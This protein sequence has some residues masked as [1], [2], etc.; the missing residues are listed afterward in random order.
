M[1]L[2]HFE[3]LKEHRPNLVEE[4]FEHRTL[5]QYI[6]LIVRKAA[7]HAEE[8]RAG[9]MSPFM[10]A[11]QV[12]EKWIKPEHAK[13]VPSDQRTISPGLSRKIHDWVFGFQ[14]NAWA[15]TCGQRQ[16]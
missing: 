6:T 2:D 11:Q 12:Y 7:S 5:A 1:W 3:W 15:W 16:N 13:S 4:L 14:S 10:A 9:G 8:M